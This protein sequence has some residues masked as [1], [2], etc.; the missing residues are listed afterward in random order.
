M[1]LI[2][3]CWMHDVHKARKWSVNC[4]LI[5]M[6]S[7][8]YGHQ[9]RSDHLGDEYVADCIHLSFS[10]IA[11]VLLCFILLALHTFVSMGIVALWV[12]Y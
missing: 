2:D 7:V 4:T 6:R 1:T 11:M 12:N 8:Q 9:T 10:S 5:V 3:L